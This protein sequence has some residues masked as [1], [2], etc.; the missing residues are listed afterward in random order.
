MS[1]EGP[2][3]PTA[4]DIVGTMWSFWHTAERLGLT[5]D[6]LDTMAQEGRVIGLSPSDSDRL[7][8]PIFQ[9][10]EDDGHVS[11]KP[12]L[13]EFIVTLSAPDG[14]PRDPWSVAIIART[15]APELDGLTPE[16]W[17]YAHRHNDDDP[18]DTGTLVMYAHRLRAE[19]AR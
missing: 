16:R 12:G 6:E 9:F 17:A 2:A 13:A 15:P 11:V 7:A 19:F 10:V 5:S 14:R 4:L 8:F 18:G 1:E 3:L